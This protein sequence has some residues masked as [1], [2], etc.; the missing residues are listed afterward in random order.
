MEVICDCA[1]VP[2]KLI[3]KGEFAAL[4]VMVML[5][6][7]VPV[8]PG[9]N[10]AVKVVLCAGL[11][12]IP[13]PPLTLNPG[14]EM[15][16]FEIVTIEFPELV[17]ITLMLPLLPT[18]TLPKFKLDGLAVSCADAGVIVTVA[19]AELVEAK[20]LCAVTVTGFAGT[21]D[22]AVYRPVDEIVP[23]DEFPP[24]MPPTNQFTAVFVVPETVAVNCCD[25][26]TWTFALVGEM[27]TETGVAAGTMVTLAFA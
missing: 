15:P 12:I 8:P 22:G 1:P 24:R 14:P 7:T 10:V 25:R 19:F 26:P 27:E 6:E 2:D 17:K 23:T 20:A 4:L 13:D 11:R 18:F 16:T 9:V 5:P 3:V 21:L